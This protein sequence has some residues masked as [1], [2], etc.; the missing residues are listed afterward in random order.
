ML[1]LRCQPGARLPFTISFRVLL[2]NV[3]CRFSGC[4][5]GMKN[6]DLPCWKP[7]ESLGSSHLWLLFCTEPV[8]QF[9]DAEDQ[10]NRIVFQSWTSCHLL[11]L[12]YPFVTVQNNHF[13]TRSQK[14]TK[15]SSTSNSW[16]RRRER[17]LVVLRS[18]ILQALSFLANH[19]QRDPHLAHISRIFDLSR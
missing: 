19:G 10:M 12:W 4:T 3:T 1:P 17:S 13:L 14:Q 6:I 11:S 7:T 15:T 8:V 5:V 18:I 16:R 2:I 9:I